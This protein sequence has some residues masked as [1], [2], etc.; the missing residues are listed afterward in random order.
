VSSELHNLQDKNEDLK[1]VGRLRYYALKLFK[2]YLEQVPP[3]TQGTSMEELLSFGGKFES[4]FETAMNL[5]GETLAQAYRDILKEN[6]GTAFSLTRDAK[7]WEKVRT[8]FD[9][10]LELIRKVRLK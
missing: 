9:R 10:N 8:Q 3:I 6:V 5:I 2:N 1:Q 7:V 4:Y